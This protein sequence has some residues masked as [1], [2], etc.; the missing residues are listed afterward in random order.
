MG[1][2]TD[3][4]KKARLIKEGKLPPTAPENEP[5]VDE[6]VPAAQPATKS[7]VERSVEAPALAAVLGRKAEKATVTSVAAAK[8]NAAAGDKVTCVTALEPSGV[9]AEEFRA[10]KQRVLSLSKTRHASGSKTKNTRVILVTSPGSAEGKTTVAAN[11][12][13]ALGENADCRVLLV[14]ADLKT[15]TIPGRFGL[16]DGTGLAELLQGRASVEEAT[17]ATGLNNVWLMGAGKARKSPEE[18]MV[19]K[20]LEAVLSQMM[21]VFR[22]VVIDGPAPTGTRASAELAPVADAVLLVLKRSRSSKRETR[23]AVKLIRNRGGE[24]LGCVLVD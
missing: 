23:E 7:A 12:A 2:M 17:V 8:A 14:D 18:L 9:S 15:P 4:L 6:S 21:S 11:L 19:P 1:K 10:L 16:E 13:L 24:I 20:R 3:A 5:V 22:Y